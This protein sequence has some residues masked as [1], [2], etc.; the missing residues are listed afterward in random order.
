ML[1]GM[2]YFSTVLLI[3][4]VLATA[5]AVTQQLHHTNHS[6]NGRFSIEQS[7]DVEVVYIEKKGYKIIHGYFCESIL[8]HFDHLDKALDAC[9]H[10]RNCYVDD[11]S[12]DRSGPFYTC[13][14][15]GTKK[16][17]ASSYCVYKKQKQRYHQILFQQ[18]HSDYKGGCRG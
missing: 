10:K 7:A 8:G 2:G 6:R 5:S 3:A 16:I 1:K 14:T 13:R 17:T 4:S 9:K 11:K 15:R 18:M 12:C